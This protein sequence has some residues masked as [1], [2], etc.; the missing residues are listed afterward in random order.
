MGARPTAE[1]HCLA[2]SQPW[3]SMCPSTLRQ[4]I[5]RQCDEGRQTAGRTG[6]NLAHARPVTLLVRFRE[7]GYVRIPDRRL[8]LRHALRLQCARARVCVRV[9]AH[10]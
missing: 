9:R 7:E 6:G 5:H 8:T 4:S 2:V 3:I 1:P 10:A